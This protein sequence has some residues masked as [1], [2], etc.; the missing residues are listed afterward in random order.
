MERFM[1]HGWPG[2][3]REL[4]NAVERAVVLGEAKPLGAGSVPG[5]A[6]VATAA[7]GDDAV[8]G[9]AIQPDVPY[10]D[11]KAAVVAAFE[12]RYVR[13][14]M[15]IHQ[16]NVSAAAR[17]AGIDRMSLHKIIERYGLDA[18]ELAKW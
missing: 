15:R 1:D 7:G 18:R 3:A 8:A 10:K 13:T 4:K 9:F 17:V 16:G 12:E 14:L 2:N 11:Q 5:G 6:A